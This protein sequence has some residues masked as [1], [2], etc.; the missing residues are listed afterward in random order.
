[1]NAYKAINNALEEIRDEYHHEMMKWLRIRRRAL[2]LGHT[3]LAQAILEDINRAESELLYMDF[4]NW[5]CHEFLF[6]PNT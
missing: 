3:K 5:K 2:A 4:R 6:N 1:M